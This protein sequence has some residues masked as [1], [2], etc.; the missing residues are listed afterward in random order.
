MTALVAIEKSSL[1]DTVII[2][3]RAVGIEGSSVYL[4][5]GELLT[6]EDLLY[7]LLLASANDAA[8]AI[9][10]YDLILGNTQTTRRK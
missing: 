4:T 7:S 9:A 2:D 6:M 5:D 10:I 3:R 1:R 8:A